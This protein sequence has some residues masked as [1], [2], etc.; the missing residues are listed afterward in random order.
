MDMNYILFVLILINKKGLS[1][2]NINKE[3]TFIVL[4]LFIF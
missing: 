4:S 1:K 3:K 2:E